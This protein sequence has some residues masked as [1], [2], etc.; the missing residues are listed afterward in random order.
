[1]SNRL[2][3]VLSL[4]SKLAIVV[5][6]WILLSNYYLRLSFEKTAITEISVATS[7]TRGPLVIPP[8]ESTLPPAPEPI[9]ETPAEFKTLPSYPNP[10]SNA[11]QPLKAIEIFDEE[12]AQGILLTVTGGIESYDYRLGPLAKGVYALGPNSKFLVYVT[13]NGMVYINRLGEPNFQTVE[14]ARRAFSA[15]NK[16]VDPYFELSFHDT[17]FVYILF[18]YEGRF[19]ET[20]QVTLPRTKTH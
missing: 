1:M 3:N 10:M 14:D 16:Q 19:G 13:N 9:T 2:K 20:L 5:L 4:V 12:T 15:L 11:S 7:P 8:L 18:I 17:G 6:V